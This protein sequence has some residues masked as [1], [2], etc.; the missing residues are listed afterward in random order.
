MS[1]R[2]FPTTPEAQEFFRQ[3]ALAP[4]EET[5][6][7]PM[8]EKTARDIE[9]IWASIQGAAS[10][11]RGKQDV[12]FP[13]KPMDRREFWGFFARDHEPRS[14]PVF[15]EFIEK[16]DGRG[17]TAI[18]LGS[19]NS[20]AVSPL[21]RKGWSII[22]VDTSRP[23]LDVLRERYPDAVA[24]GQLTIVEDDIATFTPPAPADLVLAA[25]SLSY[26]DPTQFPAT[27]RKIHDTFIKP[28]GFL[29]G[30]LFR[31]APTQ[32]QL[33]NMNL[34][35]EMGMWFL[36]DR[37]MVRP[38]LTHAGYE[39]KSCR[40]RTENIFE[41]QTGNETCIQFVAQKTD[42]VQKSAGGADG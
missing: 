39:V 41:S 33:P 7:V 29:I 30:T 26:M 13:G 35:K 14:L 4:N 2:V 23:S 21:L 38:L 36:P 17:K 12:H 25:D 20:P 9:V 40:Y 31:S 16:S 32:E 22:A 27:W 3:M 8:N 24:S 1:A 18:D 42:P 34:M 15:E 5:P 28:G 11:W 19:G 6:I 37:R 10:R